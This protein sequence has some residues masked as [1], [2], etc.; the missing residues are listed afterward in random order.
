M[1]MFTGLATFCLL[2]STSVQ[3]QIQTPIELEVFATGIDKPTD[4]VSAGDGRLFVLEKEGVIRIV[5]PDGSLLATPFLDIQSLTNT[6]GFNDERGLLGM[7]FH[8]EYSD[9]GYFFINY[10]RNNGDTRVARYTVSSD[11]NVA[12]AASAVEVVTI[13]QP[14]SNHNGGCIRFGSDGYL[15]IGMGDGGSGEDPLNA[16]QSMNTLLG[17]MLRVDID[18]DE[19]YEVPADNPFVSSGADTLPEIWASGVRNPWKFSFD[20]ETGDMFIGDV[21]QYTWEE[22][23]FQ[24]VTSLGG[25]NYGW[26]CYEGFSSGFGGGCLPFS[27]YD[28]PIL[29]YNHSG[30]RCSVTG[31]YVYRG[32]EYPNLLGKYF[33]TDYCNGQFWTVELNDADEWVVFEVLDPQGFGWSTFGQNADGEMFV[34]NQS[35]GIIYQIIDACADFN[36]IFGQV[37]NTLTVVNGS[38]FQWYLN[39]EAIDGATG[40]SYEITEDGTYSALVTDDSGCAGFTPPQFISVVG[41]S[42]LSNSFGIRLRTNPVDN[43]LWLTFG[44]PLDD[45]VR[46]SIYALNGQMVRDGSIMGGTE[47]HQMDVSELSE[48]VYEMVVSSE[49]KLSTLRF[50]VA[51]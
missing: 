51:R 11:P 36:P 45:D 30:G 23:N 15:Y 10:T 17:K 14:F 27:S 22:V 28:A 31:G 2:L 25:E 3:G 26:R 5:N 6:S 43:A 34:A 47:M 16:G 1:R 33:Y 4:I 29:D 12:D 49:E 48:G 7:A 20:M 32:S 8:P 39:G 35:S 13:D 41:L 40:Q 37:G 42:D 38:E 46:Y 19:G 9:N 21:G 44:S 50:M 24:S 18:V